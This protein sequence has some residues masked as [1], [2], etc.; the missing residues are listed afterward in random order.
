M[1]KH[2]KEIDDLDSE[3]YVGMGRHSQIVIDLMADATDLKG[4][5]EE[6]GAF[7]YSVS[8]LREVFDPKRTDDI[9]I[10]DRLEKIIRD[11]VK[12]LE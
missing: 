7:C 2:Q 1:N 5:K 3:V 8:T 10:L 11:W 6:L 12:E 4:D 9:S